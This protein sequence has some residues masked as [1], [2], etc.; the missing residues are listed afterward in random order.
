MNGQ[1]SGNPAYAVQA[2]CEPREVTAEP[3]ETVMVK[4]ILRNAGSALDRY[5]P[6]LEPDAD[7]RTAIDR[8][9]PPDVFPGEQRVW[10]LVLT[11]PQ[12]DRGTDTAAPRVGGTEVPGFDGTENGEG[13]AFESPTE[14]VPAGLDVPI[15]VASTRAPGV[16]AGALF[17][18]R[19]APADRKDGRTSLQGL[20]ESQETHHE[21]QRGGGHRR[22]HMAGARRAGRDHPPR[23]GDR[24]LQMAG[25]AVATVVALVLAVVAVLAATG[26]D[27]AKGPVPPHMARPSAFAAPGAVTSPSTSSASTASIVTVPDVV[28]KTQAQGFAILRQKGFRPTAVGTGD[29]ITSTNPAPGQKVDRVKTA[30]T[31][32]L[33]ASTSAPPTSKSATPSAAT[34]RVPAVANFAYA[35]AEAQLTALGLTVARVDE[36]SASAPGTVLRTS[37]AEG[38]MA[39]SGSTVIVTVAKEDGAMTVVPD[40]YNRYMPEAFATVQAAGLTFDLPYGNHLRMCRLRSFSPDKGAPIRKGGTIKVLHMVGC[41]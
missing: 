32:V 10:H 30:I 21:D 14:S 13:G 35:R 15:R 24:R 5:E 23:L 39:P 31:V 3:G 36:V 18:T 16:A 29:R 19:R 38:A 37:P 7:P 40:L 17:S 22:L 34:V 20:E 1:R 2:W 8:S 41:D 9:G 33:S 4:L 25:A 12:D 27:D 11:V 28:G 6:H 26:L